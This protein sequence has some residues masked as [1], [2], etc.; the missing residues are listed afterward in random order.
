MSNVEIKRGKM[1]ATLSVDISAISPENTARIVAW[2]L[3]TRLASIATGKDMTEAEADAIAK[4]EFDKWAN[5][6]FSGFTGKGGKTRLDPF[7]RY[8]RNVLVGVLVSRGKSQ[9]SAETEAKE[10]FAQYTSKE[11]SEAMQGWV[12]K[13]RKAFKASQ[14]GE[15]LPV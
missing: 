14:K 1:G 10:L 9:N 8:A 5:G 2:A 6:D 15:E 13:T 12:A 11:A 7:E 4:G 3:G